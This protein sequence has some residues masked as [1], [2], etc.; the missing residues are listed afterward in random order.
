M[1]E[2]H[3]RLPLGIELYL[4]CPNRH[5]KSAWNGCVLPANLVF[6]IYFLKGFRNISFDSETL[7]CL[8]QYLQCSH[9]MAAG[10]FIKSL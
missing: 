1:D 2:H 4:L 6:V 10:S 8:Q 7:S 5:P 3:T 9:S